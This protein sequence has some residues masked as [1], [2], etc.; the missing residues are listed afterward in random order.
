VL[1]GGDAES[2]SDT[3]DGDWLGVAAGFGGEESGESSDGG[4]LEFDDP[5]SVGVGG[6]FL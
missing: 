1:F 3:D 5:L 4:E 6:D 2:D